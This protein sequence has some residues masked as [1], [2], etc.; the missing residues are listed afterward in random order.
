MRFYDVVRK[1]IP[2]N[3]LKSS[4]ALIRVLFSSDAVR[5]HVLIYSFLPR[6]LIPFLVYSHYSGPKVEHMS[7][8][9][10]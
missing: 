5:A 6:L 10:E 9:A 8:E 3:L 1:T 4:Q 7:A 2:A